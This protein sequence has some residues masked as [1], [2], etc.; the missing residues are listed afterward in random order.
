MTRY[1]LPLFAASLAFMGF[2]R[3]SECHP[4]HCHGD[5]ACGGGWRDYQEHRTHTGPS[6]D[7]EAAACSAALTELEASIA[8]EAADRCEDLHPCGGCPGECSGCQQTNPSGRIGDPAAAQSQ[9]R[10]RDDGRYECE[11]AADAVFRC[12]CSACKH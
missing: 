11:V 2:E 7:S 8:G 6:A 10:K 3:P 5:A 9:A 1:L 12:R 4:G